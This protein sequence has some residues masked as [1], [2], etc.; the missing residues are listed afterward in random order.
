MCELFALSSRNP[1]AVTYSLPEGTAIA[2][3]DGA[4]LVRRSTL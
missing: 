3:R 4:I 1:S 2:V